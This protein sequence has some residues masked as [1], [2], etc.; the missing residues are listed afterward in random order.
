MMKLKTG[1]ML[2]SGVSHNSLETITAWVRGLA[3]I[4]YTNCQQLAA[5]YAAEFPDNMS[6]HVSK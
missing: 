2:K 6:V 4:Q 1:G 5:E 3:K